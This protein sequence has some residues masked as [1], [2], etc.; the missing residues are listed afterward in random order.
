MLWSAMYNLHPLP[1][2]ISNT[3]KGSRVESPQKSSTFTDLL[4]I[5]LHQQV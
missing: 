5:Q 4:E 1:A 3:E 2:A